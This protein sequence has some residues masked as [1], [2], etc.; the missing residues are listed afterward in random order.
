MYKIRKRYIL[1]IL[2]ACIIFVFKFAIID[3]TFVLFSIAKGLDEPS[4]LFYSV[5]E[6]I[7]KLSVKKDISEKIIKK[8]EDDKNSH[9]HDLFIKA[10]GVIGE[11]QPRA[12]N[13]IIK[14]YIKYQDDPN[15]QGI[16]LYVIDSMGFIGNQN[17]VSILERLLINYDK[18]S[19]VVPRYSIARA[20]Y[21]S[22][23]RNYE[24]F[25]ESREKKQ[26]YLTDGLRD[27]RNAIVASKGRYR[28]FPEMMVLDNLNRPDEYK[29]K[30]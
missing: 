9:L 17:T 10:L 27:A 5:T 7:Y 1:L 28:T 14:T 2:L 13:C 3:N 30:R 18:H 8:I 25:N 29:V 23:G 6:R 21:L 16:L 20:L 22:T 15:R 12:I 19:I 24:Y 11:D 4:T 26:F